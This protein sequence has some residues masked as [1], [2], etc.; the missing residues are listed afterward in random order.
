MS[1]CQTSLGWRSVWADGKAGLGAEAEP[2][3]KKS[4]GSHQDDEPKASLI[5]DDEELEVLWAEV[6]RHR[7]MLAAEH[8]TLENVDDFVT[9]SL[10]GQ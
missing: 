7:A 4:K 3:A 5:E 6:H 9:T 8:S 1:F 2:R 10:G